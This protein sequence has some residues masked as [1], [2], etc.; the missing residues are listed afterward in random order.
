MVA[1][2]P[3]HLILIVKVMVWRCS[4]LKSYSPIKN[5]AFLDSAL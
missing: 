5:F 3:V 2:L 1:V 4:I